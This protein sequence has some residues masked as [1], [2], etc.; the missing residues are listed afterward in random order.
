MSGA[1]EPQTTCAVISW[2]RERFLS[3]DDREPKSMQNFVSNL[4]DHC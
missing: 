2:G 1:V 4:P 3:P